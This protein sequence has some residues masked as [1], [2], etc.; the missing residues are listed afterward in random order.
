MFCEYEAGTVSFDQFD[1]ASLKNYGITSKT[2]VDT[3]LA[4]FSAG[5]KRESVL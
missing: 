3:L 4:R 5:F 1:D 2:Q